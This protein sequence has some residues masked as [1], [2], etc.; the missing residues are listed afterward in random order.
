MP[1]RMA[2]RRSLLKDGSSVQLVSVV[3]FPFDQ[4]ISSFLHL[5]APQAGESKGGR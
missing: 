4:P 2:S 3:F 5:S 1:K